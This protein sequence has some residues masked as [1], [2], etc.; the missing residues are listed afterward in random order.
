MGGKVYQTD[1]TEPAKAPKYREEPREDKCECHLVRGGEEQGLR[2][3]Q[4]K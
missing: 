3:L 1:G 4:V 2:A